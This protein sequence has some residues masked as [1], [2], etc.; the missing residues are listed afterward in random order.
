MQKGVKEIKP[1]Q[2][3]ELR[4]PFVAKAKSVE[5]GKWKVLQEIDETTKNSRLQTGTGILLP[6]RWV[7][8]EAEGSKDDCPTRAGTA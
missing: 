6:G 7:V 5:V 1:T 8:T 2:I 4:K 3:P